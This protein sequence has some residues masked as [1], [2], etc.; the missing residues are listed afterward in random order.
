MKRKRVGRSKVDLFEDD[1]EPYRVPEAL[2]RGSAGD[3][4]DMGPMPAMDF[5]DLMRGMDLEDDRG[6]VNAHDQL[7]GLDEL[8]SRPRKVTRGGAMAAGDAVALAR[9]IHERGEGVTRCILSGR[10]LFGDFLL[11]ALELIGPSEAR[12]A[13]LSYN[14]ENVDALWTAF[15]RGL[16][17]RMDFITSDFFFAHYRWSL[18]RMLVTHMPRERCRYA[19][20]STHAKV[21]LLIPETGPAWCIEGSANLRSC[22]A[23]EQIIVSVGDPEAVR[24]HGKWMDR[25]LDRFELGGRASMRAETWN[26]IM[27]V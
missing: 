15:Q 19:V 6:P 16:L 14:V 26:A 20:C 10:F 27:G 4:L 25:I 5:G 12:I 7:A 11:R 9:E 3:E 23:I 2:E 21:A 22:D 18:W 24:F 17:T 1:P 8:L 13:T